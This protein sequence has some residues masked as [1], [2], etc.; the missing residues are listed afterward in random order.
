MRVHRIILLALV[1]LSAAAA[2]AQTDQEAIDR[3]EEEFAREHEAFLK[4]AALLAALYE[5]KGDLESAAKLYEKLMALRPEDSH[6]REKLACV[7]ERQGRSAALLAMYSRLREKLP[8][9]RSVMVGLAQALFEADRKEDALVVIAGALEDAGNDAGVVLEIAQTLIEKELPEQAAAVI[10]KGLAQR[11]DEP[12]LLYLLAHVRL[13]TGDHAGAAQ[14]AEM[15]AQEGRPGV[16]RDRAVLLLAR[17]LREGGGGAE[18]FERNDSVIGSLEAAHAKALLE[19]AD[20]QQAAGQEEE[21]AATWRRIAQLYPDS[22][23]AA[24]ATDRLKGK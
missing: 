12:S 22:P 19:L 11:P 14:A 9:D 23:E 8:E 10:E 13:R 21:A 2:G 3:M 20:A 7:Y 15:L 17:A 24:G 18:Y 6:I 1:L 16:Y 5:E 4:K